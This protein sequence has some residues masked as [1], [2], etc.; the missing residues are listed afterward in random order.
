MSEVI[1]KNLRTGLCIQGTLSFR[2]GRFIADPTSSSNL[3]RSNPPEHFQNLSGLAVEVSELK[4]RQVKESEILI[5]AYGFAL[6]T[7]SACAAKYQTYA[8]FVFPVT[9]QYNSKTW[10]LHE[11]SF[12][13][14]EEWKKTQVIN[15]GD[16]F[17]RN[18]D[19]L[20]KKKNPRRILHFYREARDESKPIDYRVLQLWRFFEGWYKKKDA[21]LVNE[22][23]FL[24]TVRER[25]GWHIKTGAP[26]FVNYKVTKRFAN[27]F[28][29]YVRCAVAHGGGARTQQAKKVFYPLLLDFYTDIDLDLHS[30]QKIADEVLRRDNK[31][32]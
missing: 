20:N 31:L 4:K 13:D 29:K 7:L 2:G 23:V 22:I 8:Y 17:C 14:A 30:M 9:C 21:A 5:Q 10:L 15:G 24:K 32:Y 12:E 28:Y 1:F 27:R 26:V 6:M 3:P 18:L 25:I 11:G 16:G 19:F